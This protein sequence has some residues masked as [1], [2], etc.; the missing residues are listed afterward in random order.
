MNKAFG[1][2]FIGILVY[3]TVAAAEPVWQIH[4]WGTFT[5][6]QDESGQTLGGI[7]TDDKP[8]P[9]FVHGAFPIIPANNPFPRQFNKGLPSSHPDVTMRLETPVI[10]FHAP[11]GASDGQNANVQVRFRGGWLTEYYPN[12]T[13]DD[14]GLTNSF[15]LRSDTMG[16]L[17]WNN[18]QVGGDWP[19]TEATQESVWTSPR[20]VDASLVKNE[21]GESEKFLFYRGVG[22]IDAP[23][24]IC[25][26]DNTGKLF[27]RSHVGQ[28]PL[29]QPLAIRH[30][31]L[32]DIQSGGKIAFRCLPGFALS[33]D[34]NSILAS[35]PAAFAP[36]E[37][38]A[39][40]LE[41]LKNSLKS[42]LVSEG[43]FPDES[44]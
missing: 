26:N 15:H 19:L 5:S 9:P 35:T 16:S 7:N 36:G 33:A 38:S 23:F 44:E 20:N 32:V 34:T 21:M 1:W 17:A 13:A 43:L 39:A 4:E 29:D 30:V 28:M 8:V 22:H 27:F 42:A 10:Y 31:W 24:L 11:V 6:S 14:P 18:L 40:N 37:F 3:S 41:G 12:A 25:R 2:C